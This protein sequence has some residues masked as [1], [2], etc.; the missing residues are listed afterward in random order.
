[1][2]ENVDSALA[3]EIHERSKNDRRQLNWAPFIHIQTGLPAVV[4]GTCG[5][6]KTTSAYLL[7]KITGRYYANLSL[8]QHDPEDVSGYGKI[9]TE[10]VDG[11]ELQFVR[12]VQIEQIVKAK[13][14]PSILCLDE[15]GSVDERRQAAALQLLCDETGAYSNCWMLGCANPPEIAANGHELSLPAVNRLMIT[16]WEVDI[17]AHQD[18]S[19]NRQEYPMPSLPI[20]PPREQWIGNLDYWGSLKADYIDCG[21][22]LMVAERD[23]D[24]MLTEGKPYPSPRTWSYFERFGA[25][26]MS[27]GATNETINKGMDGLL[28]METAAMFREHISKVDLP[29]P[30]YVMDNAST[31][32]LPTRSDLTK[33]VLS[34]IK[35][36]LDIKQDPETWELARDFVET[37]Y[38]DNREWIQMWKG[39]LWKTKPAD[40]T[41][42][43]RST[44]AW[45]EF[46]NDSIAIAEARK[47]NPYR[48]QRT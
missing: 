11:T 32:K 14:Q 26:A 10:E 27:V 29:N 15:L 1:M 48:S 47:M 22:R 46:M 23:A 36:Y 30:Q 7:S 44:P 12:K 35:N 2:Y 42:E 43:R 21:G 13:A 33:A 39:E 37:N 3:F 41:P 16:E 34:S 19:R 18:G 4:F 9:M 25:A 20:V 31:Y 17:E 8:S 6:A 38:V 45:R 40:Y 24:K 5:T 28:G